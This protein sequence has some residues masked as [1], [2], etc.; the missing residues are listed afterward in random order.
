MSVNTPFPIEELETN[1]Q[2]ITYFA[3]NLPLLWQLGR[4]RKQLKHDWAINCFQNPCRQNDGTTPP[5]SYL[6]QSQL[7]RKYP[8]YVLHASKRF[9]SLTAMDTM[10]E[11]EE[12][13]YISLYCSDYVREMIDSA[14]FHRER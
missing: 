1:P 3:H 8:Y 2:L 5:E 6:S 4:S 10:L 12:A 7:T 11:V 13:K 9:K 14:A